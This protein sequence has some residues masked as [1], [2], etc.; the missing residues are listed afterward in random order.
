MNRIVVATHNRGKLREIRQRLEQLSCD[1]MCLA[2]FDD[3]FDIVEDAD[4]FE[5]NARKKAR[6]VAAKTGLPTL[7][8]DSGLE[9]DALGGRP[10][11]Y[12]ARYGGDD[13]N[14]QARYTL[15][16]EELAGVVSEER[17]ARFRV[18]LVFVEPKGGEHLF[19]GTVEGRIATVP[20]GTHGFGYDPVFVPNGYDAPMAK[21]GPDIKRRISHR[22]Q[23]LDAFAAWFESRHASPQL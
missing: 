19:E 21:L 8:D 2:D 7:A 15:L 6:V 13:L 11:V 23:A 22:A 16:L 14:D 4:S 20:R 9:V 5:G 1:V 17:T 3:P 12:S 18:A 10:G